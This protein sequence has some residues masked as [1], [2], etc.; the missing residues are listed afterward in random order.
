MVN[1]GLLF[2][3]GLCCG[4]LSLTEE[5]EMRYLLIVGLVMSLTACATLYYR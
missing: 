3:I 1:A 2:I 4:L 5:G